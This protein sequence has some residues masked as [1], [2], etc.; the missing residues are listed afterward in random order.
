MDVRELG[1]EGLV[2]SAIGLGTAAF[3][4]IYGAASRRDCMRVVDVALESGITLLD[5]ADFY[6]DGDI[7]RLLGMSVGA[8]RP[9]VLLCT[10]GGLRTARDGSPPVVDGHPEYLAAACEASLRRLGTDYI[11]LYHLSQVDPQVP[12]EESV[13]KLAEL[14]AAGKIRYIGLY[15][16]SADDLRRAAAVHRISALAVDYSLRNRAAEKGIL[17][18]AA[19]MGMG[20]VAYCPLAQGRLSCGDPPASAQERQS[21][22]TLE[23][24]AAGLDIGMA[25]LAL[26]WL[27]RRN[28]IPTPSSR[29]AA[30]IEMDASAAGIR[31]SSDVCSRLEDAFPP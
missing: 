22:H 16:A 10:H 6:A 31:L 9:R 4:G 7:E 17:A 15:K 20:V 2:S 28:V 23:A 8:R 25:R 24:E 13:G 3:T 19:E 29:N 12:V 14:V 1:R 11:D 27:C 5:S 21:L 30:H 18:T 26:A